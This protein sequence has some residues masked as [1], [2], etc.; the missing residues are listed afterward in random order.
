MK[1][2]ETE[3]G[4]AIM[5]QPCFA[6]RRPFGFNPNKVPSVRDGNGIRQPVCEACIRRANMERKKKGIPEFP[7]PEDA[8]SPI[9]EMEL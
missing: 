1:R 4:Y 6:C 5:L 2:K 8:Y 9:D 3:M 7:I